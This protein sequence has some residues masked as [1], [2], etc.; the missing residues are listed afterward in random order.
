MSF[1][2][3]IQKPFGFRHE[4]QQFDGI[5]DFLRRH[6]DRSKEYCYCIANVSFA[7]KDNSR[8]GQYDIVLFHKNSIVIVE[9]KNKKGNISGSLNDYYENPPLKI[10]YYDGFQEELPIFQIEKEK[11]FLLNYLIND[12]GKKPNRPEGQKYRVDV[13]MVFGDGSDYSNVTIDPGRIGKWFSICTTSEFEKIYLTRNS[14]QPFSLTQA[15]IKYIAF[16][17]FNTHEADPQTYYIKQNSVKNYLSEVVDSLSVRSDPQS[18]LQLLNNRLYDELSEKE[19]GEL[20]SLRKEVFEK[21]LPEKQN[22]EWKRY[23]ELFSQIDI[24]PEILLEIDRVYAHWAI[25]LITALV[26]ELVEA[27]L[28]VKAKKDQYTSE[29]VMK[30]L[31]EHI[32]PYSI[33]L[34]E[35]KALRD[36][37]RHIDK[38]PIYKDAQIRK[39]IVT[40]ALL[41]ALDFNWRDYVQKTT[42]N[43]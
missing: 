4:T 38:D 3:Y 1:H 26:Q 2:L 16:S 39:T 18:K 27:F 29:I 11:K 5:L 9:M 24:E 15:D 30:S 13:L 42:G 10:E 28:A 12:F 40:S 17:L 41:R 23:R 35:Y 37:V 14:E 20:Q 19:I 8:V 34:G 32:Q 31:I 25:D 22:P 7:T 43:H 33:L 36:E 6:Y 21:I